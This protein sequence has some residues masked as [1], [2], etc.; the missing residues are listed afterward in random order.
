MV[1]AAVAVVA[2]ADAVYLPSIALGELYYGAFHAAAAST[3]Y[4]RVRHLESDSEVVHPDSST[5]ETYG[6]LKADLR[7]KGR[8]IPD[9]D[10]WIA[11]LAIQ[12]G[13]TVMTQDAHFSEVS[14]LLTIG[15]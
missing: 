12:H 10:L 9:N 5:A 7:A 14:G 15:W 13:L 8:M 1:P 4:A 2:Q 11:A 3:Q 6:R